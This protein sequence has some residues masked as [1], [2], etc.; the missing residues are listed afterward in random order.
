MK[1]I[2]FIK[3]LLDFFS[4]IFVEQ[5]ISVLFIYYKYSAKYLSNIIISRQNT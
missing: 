1:Q 4:G 2:R 3:I 5:F